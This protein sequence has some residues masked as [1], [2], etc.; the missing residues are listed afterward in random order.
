[1]DAAALAE[2][3]RLRRA[4]QHPFARVA[5]EWAG[6]RTGKTLSDFRIGGCLL[7]EMSEASD[8]QLLR[9]YVDPGQNRAGF[10]GGINPTLMY[11]YKVMPA[12]EPDVRAPAAVAGPSGKKLNEN[13]KV[14]YQV[15]LDVRFLLRGSPWIVGVQV[16]GRASNQVRGAEQ[17]RAPDQRAS[18]SGTSHFRTSDEQ[19]TREAL[20]AEA[21]SM[22]DR[23]PSTG[24]SRDRKR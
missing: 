9:E 19:R 13:T 2:A 5:L 12:V 15:V 17:D 23:V 22:L 24:G 10:A 7:G 3:R 6:I 18:Y 11:P 1:M 8:A 14:H 4:A 21:T 16:R 20:T